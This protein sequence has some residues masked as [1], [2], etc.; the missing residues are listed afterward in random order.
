MRPTLIIN[1][2]DRA[3]HI[4]SILNGIAK[5]KLSGIAMNERP[6]VRRY[7][8]YKDAPTMRAL[9]VEML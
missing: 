2:D 6:G 8:I 7:L 9:F 5:P 1:D 3:L 4:V